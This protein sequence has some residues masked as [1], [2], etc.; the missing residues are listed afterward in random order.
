MSVSRSPSTIGG[1]AAVV[2]S[3]D[4]L[5]LTPAAPLSD[6][7]RELPFVL[8][9]QNSRGEVELSVRGSDSRQ[10]AV[11]FDGLPLTTGWDHRSDASAFP[12]S[13]VGTIVVVR[14]LSSVLQGPN[15]LGG[16]IDLGVVSD[17]SE[18][19]RGESLRLATG[20]DQLGTQAY[21]LDW[22][23]GIR[24]GAGEWTFR[25]GG[26]LRDREAIALSGGV[27]DKYTT[28]SHRLT[29][30]DVR[31][32]DLYT[33][34]RYQTA[35]GAWVGGSYS[36]NAMERGVVP[37]LHVTAPRFW[38]YPDQTRHLGVVSLGTG[39]RRTPLGSGDLEVVVGQNNS[40]LFIESFLNAQY[41]SI[42][43][44]ERGR[45]RTSTARLLADHSL[46][47]GEL[48][49]AFTATRVRYTE[50]LNA[51]APSEYEQNLWS[52][53][54]EVDMPIA[55]ALRASA[56][57]AADGSTT[58]ETGGKTSLGRL[59]EWGGRFGLST[60]A[61][62]NRVRFHTSV[63]RRARFAAL[64]ELYSGALNRFEPN[65]TLQPERLVGAELGATLLS[66]R[67]QFQAVVFRHRLEDAIVR[68][69]LPNRR[70]KRVNRD[71]LRS[72]GLELLAGWNSGGFSITSDALVQRLRIEDPA[73]SGSE[74]KPE[75]QPEFRL[76]AD[77]AFPTVAGVRG[78]LGF[79]HTGTQYCVNPDLGRNQNLSSQTWVN[80]GVERTF[81]L[82]PSGLLSRLLAS[83][84][85]DNIGDSA[86]YDQ[87]GLP[88]A[89][90]TLRFG[91]S[92]M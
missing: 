39:R 46:G 78:R 61:L 36:A 87:C 81:S 12:L 25:A 30:S 26:G 42:V 69:T 47:A 40:S 1:A 58:P 22:A 28:D 38:R 10:A 55:G 91:L 35:G 88:F 56:G 23:R 74:R 57:Y 62:G 68:I 34:L 89:G 43:A 66:S 49:T 63:S 54:V 5:R 29:N 84:S 16:V 41:D 90:R 11:L 52:S 18:R 82:R 73:V 50:T 65:P 85:I 71:E 3:V 77:A 64:R 27:S 44:T 14:G 21:H 31:Q 15:A 83:L 13:G 33:A 9:R 17:R 75:H 32:R 45:E 60:M 72:A 86:V 92:L 79:N 80:G 51:A 76:G 48:R 59:S 8:V 4:S 70:F 24:A 2:T 37:E 53:G 20:F 7:L 19:V 6:A 67:A